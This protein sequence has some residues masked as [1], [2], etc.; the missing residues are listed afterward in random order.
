MVCCPKVETRTAAGI[1]LVVLALVESL[2]VQR[3]RYI[4][5]DLFEPRKAILVHRTLLDRLFPYSELEI[6]GLRSVEEISLDFLEMLIGNL[7]ESE[8]R[9]RMVADQETYGCLWLDL[10][11]NGKAVQQWRAATLCYRC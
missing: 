6:L 9:Q 7:L 8:R 5:N 2:S 10:G 4:Q 3:Q 1:D 11:Q